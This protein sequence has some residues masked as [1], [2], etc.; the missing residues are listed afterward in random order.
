MDDKERMAKAQHLETVVAQGDAH[1]LGAALLQEYLA[2]GSNREEFG[3][4]LE[5]TK[6]L[7][8]TD[9]KR[10]P[11]LPSIDF[12]NPS[13]KNLEVDMGNFSAGLSFLFTGELDKQSTQIFE[14][15]KENP[16][17]F[18]DTPNDTIRDQDNTQTTVVDGAK[19]ETVMGSSVL[20]TQN[21]AAV[22]AMLPFT[23][24]V[25]RPNST[26][27]V[28]PWYGDE[29]VCA[30]S[31]ATVQVDYKLEYAEFYAEPKAAVLGGVDII[32]VPEGFCEKVFL[33]TLVKQM[34]K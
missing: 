32:P 22:D 12:S 3:K 26:L 1:K 20:I 13:A 25:A 8:E 33:P 34:A 18:L 28:T 10:F 6:E 29:K 16:R 24:G 4:L 27:K 23:V 7:N 15:K 30:E 2:T 21:G 19:S 14:I 31:G 9:R 11:F 17:G 5:K